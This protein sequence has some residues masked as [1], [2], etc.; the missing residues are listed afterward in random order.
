MKLTATKIKRLIKRKLV[1]AVLVT[2][3]IAAFATLG[4]DGG[5]KG[6]SSAINE[7]NI[8]TFSLRTP[9]NYKS[10]NLFNSSG[11]RNFIM[12]NTVITYQKGNATYVLPLKKKVILN[13]IK[14]NPS[15]VR[16]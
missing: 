12:L 3:Y 9:Y 10:N 2:A 8:R 14:F 1:T 15:P 13:K 7:F 16:F 11:S 4:D 5:K 6:T